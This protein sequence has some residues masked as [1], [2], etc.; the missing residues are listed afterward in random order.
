LQK[1]PAP[2]SL[3]NQAEFLIGLNYF[4][5][6]DYA[7]AVIAFQGLPS[8]HDVLL[9]LGAALSQKG[10]TAPAL[11]AWKQAA[12]MDPLASDAF[13][14]IGYLSFRKGDFDSAARNLSESLKVRGR[15]SEA[16]FWLGR[17]YERLGRIEESQRAIS[18]AV[19]LSQRVE[20]WMN[21]PLPDLNRLAPTT[22]FLS[23][24]DTWTEPRLARRARGQDL[25]ARLESIQTAIDSYS[26]GD[27]LR[28]LQ[29]VIRVYP[30]SSEA[31]SLLEEVHRRQRGA[32]GR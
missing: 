15:D 9:N 19:R 17:T 4:Y 31:R 21:Q 32:Q 25:P 5:L 22:S 1:I 28:E 11:I 8:N 20:R 26:Y 27:A 12:E 16:L 13:F 29:N 3:L 6:N 30:E 23:Y 10:D 24:E 2:S 18:R 7:R 14:N